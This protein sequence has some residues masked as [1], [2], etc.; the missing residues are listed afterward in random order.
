MSEKRNEKTKY[1]KIVT[2]KYNYNYLGFNNDIIKTPLKYLFI[3]ML[4]IQYIINY[5]NSLSVDYYDGGVLS[6]NNTTSNLDTASEACGCDLKPNSCDPYC[7]CDPVCNNY[8]NGTLQWRF[9]SQC[10]NNPARAQR[11]P[12]CRYDDYQVSLKDLYSPIRV[13]SQNYKKG[14]CVSF[15]NSGLNNSLNIKIDR[16]SDSYINTTFEFESFIKDEKIKLINETLPYMKNT[17]NAVPNFPSVSDRL[18]NS[19]E[20]RNYTVNDNLIVFDSKSKFK[21]LKIPY[22]GVYGECEHNFTAVKFLNSH[23]VTCG[24]K[25]VSFNY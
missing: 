18:F 3:I 25:L 9:F 23:K 20:F 12:R 16:E 6:A 11:F 21:S 19:T 1:K 17:S 15:D 8:R 10:W 24:H 4:V 5:V 7:C 22:R 14:L 2:K 13:I